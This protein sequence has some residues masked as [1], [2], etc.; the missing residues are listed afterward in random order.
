MKLCSAKSKRTGKPCRN[1]AVKGHSVCRMHGAGSP[2]RV[3]AGTRKDPRTAA[4]KHG[5]YATKT[6]EALGGVVAEFE[7][8]LEQLYRL[9]TMQ[10]RLWALL[11]RLDAAE[12]SVDLDSLIPGEGVEEDFRSQDAAKDYLSRVAGIEKIL[13]QLMAGVRTK[14]RIEEKSDGA[15]SR[16]QVVAMLV[17][18]ASWVHEIA[19]DE[20]IP[21]AEISSVLVGKY[22]QAKALLSE[23]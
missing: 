11:L 17:M 14:Q 3:K 4:L 5:L 12:Q 8:D 16:Q 19:T 6:V 2:S 9:D 23:D 21:R 18:I 20:S 10:A 1:Y 7:D 15:V 13:S 22:E